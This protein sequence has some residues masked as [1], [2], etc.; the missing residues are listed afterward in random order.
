MT[1]VRERPKTAI[2]QWGVVRKYSITWQ[3]MRRS[4]R[5][6]GRP[7]L[8]WRGRHTIRNVDGV[9]GPFVGHGVRAADREHLDLGPG[10]DGRH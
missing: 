10:V 7:G 8:I 2:F 1:A 4:I 6:A 5:D 3:G 9:N